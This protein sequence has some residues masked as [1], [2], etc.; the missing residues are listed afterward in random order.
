MNKYSNMPSATQH[1]PMLQHPRHIRHSPAIT[2]HPD[3][4]SPLLGTARC[5]AGGY[6]SVFT[7]RCA[8]L[9]LVVMSV[10][11]HFKTLLYFLSLKMLFLVTDW[12]MLNGPCR[13]TVLQCR[14]AGFYDR[15]NSSA[16]HPLYI[17]SQWMRQSPLTRRRRM[18]HKTLSRTWKIREKGSE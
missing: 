18:T 14:T 17:Y 8:L 7:G 4:S 3:S 10:L 11:D 2:P 12:K 15:G 1:M 13:V 9:V 16:V 5:S 6:P